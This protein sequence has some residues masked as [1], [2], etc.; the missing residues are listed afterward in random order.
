MIE[1]IKK[2]ERNTE[3]TGIKRDEK[4]KF[5]RGTKPKPGPGRTKGV[6]DFDTYFK[7]AVKKVAKK[8]KLKPKDVDVEIVIRGI[9]EALGGNY[10]FW[11]DIIE[12]RYGK[13]KDKLEVD[14]NFKIGRELTEEEMNLIEKVI[15]LDYGKSNQKPNSADGGEENEQ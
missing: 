12:R 11:K 14:G 4:G 10:N 7:K 3:E 1:E 6:L 15:K 9:S 5:V 13:V 8:L 2:P